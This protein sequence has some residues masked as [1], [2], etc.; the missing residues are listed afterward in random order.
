[1][2]V[3]IINRNE[4]EP[5]WKRSRRSFILPENEKR[6][7]YEYGNRVG[8]SNVVIPQ[9]EEREMLLAESDLHQLIWILLRLSPQPQI[10]PSW[11]GYNIAVR[12]N[13]APIKANIGYLENINSS[14]TEISTIYEIFDRCLRIKEILSLDIIV[15]V[16]P[17]NIF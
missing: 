17:S 15:C 8:P 5:K 7:S 14:A 13:Q 10:V 4:L 2:G 6:L 1:M 9:N 3:P 16:R 11:T 12:N